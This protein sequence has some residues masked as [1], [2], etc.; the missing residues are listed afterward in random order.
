MTANALPDQAIERAFAC[1]QRHAEDG[2]RFFPEGQS[3]STRMA[4]SRGYCQGEPYTSAGKIEKE[5]HIFL[6]KRMA[7]HVDD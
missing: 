7:Q 2:I 5:K 6:A 4:Y 3:A 1:G